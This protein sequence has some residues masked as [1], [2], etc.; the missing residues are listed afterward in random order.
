MSD[1]GRKDFSQKIGETVKPDSEKSTWEKGKETVT[2]TTDKL[3]GKLQPEENK[4][5]GQGIN[6]SAESGKDKANGESV[7]DQAKDYYEGAKQKLNDAVEYVSK[8]V[9]GGDADPA[10]K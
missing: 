1:P 6:D 7:A 10:N 2:D 3:A 5:L 8:S 9:H 4:G